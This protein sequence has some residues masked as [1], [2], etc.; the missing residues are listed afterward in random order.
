MKRFGL[1]GLILLILLGIVFLT[2]C[3][4]IF[5]APD[6]CTPPITPPIETCSLTVVAGYWIWG[7]IEYQVIS[8][9][10]II[11]T[12]KYIDYSG[13]NQVVIYN[14]PCGKEIWVYI[15]DDCNY[16]SH[17]ESIILQ[18]GQQNYLYFTYW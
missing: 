5:T 2:G 1:I 14:M 4:I 9:G 16:V 11:N 15:I 6:C 18:S 10:Q 13:M 8:T 7:T 12:G 17:V 3:S